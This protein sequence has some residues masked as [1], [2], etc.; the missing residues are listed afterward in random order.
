MNVTIM[1]AWRSV[2]VCNVPVSFYI[3]RPWCGISHKWCVPIC[4]V[5]SL[6]TFKVPKCFW[7]DDFLVKILTYYFNFWGSQASFSFW[8]ASWAYAS[9]PDAYALHGL[10]ALFKFRIFMHTLSIRVINWCVCSACASVPDAYAQ[11]T[12][13]FLTRTL[14]VRV[15]NWCICS[16]WFEGTALLKL[17]WAFV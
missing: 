8:C 12:H 4:T 17:D 9:I 16:A 5:P 13:Q 1:V 15:R 2:P 6:T 10:K 7:V 11:W 14:R 3:L